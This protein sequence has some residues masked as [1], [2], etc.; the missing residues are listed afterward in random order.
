MAHDGPRDGVGNEGQGFLLVALDGHGVEERLNLLSRGRGHRW[1]FGNGVFTSI[2][3]LQEQEIV[4][5]CQ[6]K[7]G[8]GML[9]LGLSGSVVVIFNDNPLRRYASAIAGYPHHCCLALKLSVT[10]FWAEV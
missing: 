10:R 3:G 1:G 9:Y 5:V 8:M 7:S 6:I 2:E 4:S